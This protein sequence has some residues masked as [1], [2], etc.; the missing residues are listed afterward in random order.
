MSIIFYDRASAIW[1]TC[2]VI[3]SLDSTYVAQVFPFYNPILPYSF[4]LRNC[5]FNPESGTVSYRAHILD[6]FTVCGG[7][8]S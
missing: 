1:S 3:T 2:D 4:L 6:Y 7:D 8:R 5:K